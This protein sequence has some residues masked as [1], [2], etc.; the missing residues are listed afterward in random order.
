MKHYINLA[1]ILLAVS[2]LL[3][4]MN[5]YAD[6]KKNISSGSK[7]EITFSTGGIG[8]EERLKMQNARTTSNLHLSFALKKSGEYLTD[9]KVSI[10]DKDGNKI[11]QSDS[12]GPLLYAM[13]SPGIYKISAQYRSQV[14]SKTINIKSSSSK[15]L[16]FYWDA[17]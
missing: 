6:D 14:F 16:H 7:H 11:L 8:E 17:E 1:N 10:F 2:L 9:V 13:L 3:P 12:S 4:V 15:E 5:S